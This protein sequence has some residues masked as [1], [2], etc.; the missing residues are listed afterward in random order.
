MQQPLLIIYTGGTIGMQPSSAGY[1]A[2]EGIQ[3]LIESNLS[4]QAIEQLKPISS[5]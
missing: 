4:N 2:S 1:Q 5:T 3:A